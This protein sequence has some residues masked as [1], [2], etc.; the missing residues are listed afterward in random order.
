MTR[1]PVLKVAAALAAALLAAVLALFVFLW[2]L[3]LDR[4]K[5]LL[6]ERVK[7][8][9]GRD[10]EIVGALVPAFGLTPSLRIDGVT[11]SNAAWGAS[12]PMLSVETFEARLRLLPLIT[13]LG[14]RI[15][16]ERILLTGAELWLET[17][18][19]GAAN[20][21][22]AERPTQAAASP[23]AL[24][25]RDD[26][27]PA[28][29]PAIEILDLEIRGVRILAKLGQAEPLRLAIDR[30]ALRGDGETGPRLIDGH[31][32]YQRLP[33][34][35]AGRLGSSA[36]IGV[37]PLP[38]DLTVRSADRASLK[39]GGEL[40]RPLGGRDYDIAIEAAMPE[41][42]R[43]G[44]LAAE[45]GLAGIWAPPLGAFVL[46]LDISDRGP[47]GRVA[48]DAVR[49]QLGA[50]DALRLVAEGA[51]RDPLGPIQDPPAPPGIDLRL[52]G[53]VSDGAVLA[54]RI[55]A[56]V[57]PAGPVRIGGHLHDDGGMSVALTAAHA[58]A[59]W[60]ELS[61]HASLD[62]GAA[63][64]AAS[65]HMEGR[66]IDLGWLA[67]PAVEPAA[68]SKAAPGRQ[69]AARLIP[70]I[71]IPHDL[72][73]AVDLDAGLAVG[74][75]VLPQA[76]LEGLRVG[77]RRDGHVLALAPLRFAMDGGAFDLATTLSAQT[78]TIQ[79]RIV[80]DGLDLGA[81][82][83]ARRLG[84][85]VRGGRTS[86]RADLRAEGEGLRDAARSLSGDI[87]MDIGAATIG[88][89]LRG[90]LATWL[91]AIAPSLA[92]IQ[93]GTS[94]R[95]AAYALRFDRG[96]GTLRQG[97]IDAG[98]VALRSAG[99]IDLGAESIAVRSQLGPLGFRTTGSLADPQ[100]RLDATGTARGVAEGATGIA[101]GVL[102]ALGRDGTPERS[103]CDAPNGAGAQDGAPPARPAPP[104]APT[105]QPALPGVLRDLLGR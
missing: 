17:D 81:A 31:G 45:I 104:A 43:L 2:S 26:L 95:C 92:Q 73:R 33:F 28:A 48:L 64:P 32:S 87:D 54:R 100:H 18:A 70:D 99:T 77:L 34:A 14:Q 46:G 29:L 16:V 47:A 50:R 42:G 61:G 84:D 71:P 89:G 21:R 90:D 8:A 97:V 15:V 83:A 19:S 101:R 103:G 36:G 59:P 67:G 85:L 78:R 51:I 75:L 91:G 10:L 3:D 22:F 5:P 66:R 82:L 52:D 68:P 79:Q 11:L 38:F 69:P 44:E 25:A 23:Q 65:L 37:G 60:M 88:Q 1:G 74:E 63:R 102:G 40:R 53:S 24:G 39:F 93:F 6:A 94:L 7:A 76:R 12:R 20:W 62:L 9:T 4:Y 72:L 49:F 41:I 13:S 86:L 57:P 96:V 80:V 30:A 35:F 105:L 55:G 58:A 98:M 56:P 27:R